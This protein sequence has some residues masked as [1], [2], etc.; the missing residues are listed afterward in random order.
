M[1]HRNPAHLHVGLPTI[2]TLAILVV[3]CAPAS[4]TAD[5]MPGNGL[6]AFA[7]EELNEQPRLIQCSD[8]IGPTG[9]TI[10]GTL[11]ERV[12][13]RFIVTEKGSVDAASV[14][15]TVSRAVG[16]ARAS[17]ASIDEAKQRALTCRYEPGRLDGKVVRTTMERT[18]RI[19]TQS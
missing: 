19:V 18:F 7:P 8:A 2:A 4:R 9:S 16:G 17:D 11:V 5:A 15:S 10:H 14:F 12:T 6:V 13:V 1:K 3:Q